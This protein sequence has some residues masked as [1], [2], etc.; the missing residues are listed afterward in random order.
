MQMI[1]KPDDYPLVAAVLQIAQKT[2]IIFNAI[3]NSRKTSAQRRKRSFTG[4]DNAG[5]GLET[6][7]RQGRQIIFGRDA[8]AAKDHI[9]NCASRGFH[10]RTPRGARGQ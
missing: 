3:L 9:L 2:A 5:P 7:Y 6:Q 1:G 10:V 8:S 4:I